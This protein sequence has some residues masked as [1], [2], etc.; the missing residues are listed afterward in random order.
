MAILLY[1][2]TIYEDFRNSQGVN[3]LSPQGNAMFL[4]VYQLQ[5]II[6]FRFK[7]YFVFVL[8]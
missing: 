3:T 1:I 2:L 7:Y 6:F 5:S 4:K 8:I